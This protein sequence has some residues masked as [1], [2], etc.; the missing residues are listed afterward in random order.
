M[1]RNGR[2]RLP[3]MSG[4]DKTESAVTLGRNTQTVFREC[5]IRDRKA[6]INALS[7]KD[8]TQVREIAHPIKGSGSSFGYPVLTEKAKDVCDAFDNGKVEWLPELTL[9]L[10]LELGKLNP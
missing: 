9:D 4:H 1:K 6:L 8:W 3:G 10:A 5:S 7:E 2:S